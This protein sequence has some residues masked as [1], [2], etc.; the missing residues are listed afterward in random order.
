MFTRCTATIL[1]SFL[2]DNCQMEMTWFG[3]L[4][5]GRIICT[6]LSK[7]TI[8]VNC[9]LIFV[10]FAQNFVN[11]ILWFTWWAFCGVISE[12]LSFFWFFSLFQLFI[13]E[14]FIYQI[15]LVV[16]VSRALLFR[17]QR[18]RSFGLLCCL[19]VLQSEQLF[20]LTEFLLLSLL[21]FHVA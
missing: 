19:L 17:T 16:I 9:S 7:K 18:K 10:T 2:F 3:L 5:L 1:E 6:C 13:L 14:V 4:L 15:F 8:L 20:L 12:K 11:L 21:D